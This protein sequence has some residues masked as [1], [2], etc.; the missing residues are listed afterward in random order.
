MDVSKAAGSPR[1][2]TKSSSRGRPEG[3][4]RPPQAAP[5]P[6]AT[7][8]PD[9]STLSPEAARATRS[10]SSAGDHPSPTAVD[11]QA[12]TRREQATE[13]IS[14]VIERRHENSTSAIE[15]LPSLVSGLAA[16][17]G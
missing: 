2:K 12:Q 3:Q 1:P 11:H 7:A 9:R 5:A 15:N 6:A 4:A 17:F 14:S 10:P 13:L 8:R 16:N